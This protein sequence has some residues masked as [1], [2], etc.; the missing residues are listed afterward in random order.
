E[1]KVGLEDQ[2]VDR[3]AV[4]R[5]ERAAYR[6]PNADL[7]LIYEVGLLDRIDDAVGKLLDGLAA[8]RV[9]HNDREFVAA[10]APDMA[11]GTDL[12]DQ[13]LGDCAKH[14]IA[15]GMAESVVDR[16]EAVEVEEHDRTRH[17]ATG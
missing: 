15:L 16:L 7:G 14:R 10:H 13:P 2:V 8:L 1:R 9:N 12:V 11:I 6:H 17:I 3:R 4:D 5:A